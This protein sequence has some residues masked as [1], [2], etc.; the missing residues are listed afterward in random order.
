MIAN[1]WVRA[2]LNRM[3]KDGSLIRYLIIVALALIAIPAALQTFSSAP[4]VAASS[5]VG[6]GREGK[7]PDPLFGVNLSGAEARDNDVLRPTLNDVKNYIDRFGFKL[8]RYPFKPER[9][10]PERVA[11]LRILTNY[12][13]SK[14]VP[15]ILDAH[16]FKWLP[17]S[18]M[19]AFWT[20]FARHFPDDGSVMLDLVNEPRGFDDPILVNSWD[21]WLRDSN[22]IIAG[23][24][25]NGIKHPILLEYPQ[26]SGLSR[27]DRGERNTPGFLQ[28]CESA[29]CSIDRGG[30]LQDPLKLTYI[31]A[32]RYFDKDRS[33][34]SGVCSTEVSGFATFAEQLR[35]RNLKAYITESAF[36]SSYGIHPSCEA[37]AKEAIEALRANSDVIMG[38]TWWGGGRIWPEHYM[39]KVEPQ[40]SERFTAPIPTYIKTLTGQ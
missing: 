12:A 5:T 34:T 30:G 8:I 13:R 7:C 18:E 1:R 32:H 10:T 36:G 2:R 40:K 24:R 9:M 4:L 21:Q 26:W 27:F 14:H 35:K 6:C 25:A 23:L 11:E 20:E 31:N 3:R 16:T 38:I 33:G 17:P 39:F 15:V 19:I 28:P 37:V 29:A 22:L